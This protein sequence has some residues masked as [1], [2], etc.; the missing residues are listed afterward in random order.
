M[1]EILTKINGICQ[2]QA[3]KINNSADLQGIVV[4][5]TGL[6]KGLSCVCYSGTLY[7]ICF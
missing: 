2:K 1:T 6:E 5:P 4:N 3:K 7:K